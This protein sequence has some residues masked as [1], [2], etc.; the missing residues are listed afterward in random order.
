VGRPGTDTRQSLPRIDGTAVLEHV[1]ILASDEFEGRAPGTRGEELTV[2][3]IIERLQSLGL[4]PGNP[5]G[6]YV[7]FVPLVGTTVRNS[8]TMTF[9][10]AGGE[11]GWLGVR[12]TC[13]GRSARSRA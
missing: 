9:R 3:Y 7:Q 2:S 8:P 10:S 11:R 6:T 12:T 4:R 5:D 13:P 1:R